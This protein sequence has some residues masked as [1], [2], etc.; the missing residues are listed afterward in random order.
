ME[1]KESLE[2]LKS[3]KPFIEWQNHNKDSFFSYALKMLEQ[4]KEQPWELGYYNQNTEKIASFVIEPEARMVNEEEAFKKPDEEIKPIDMAKVTLPFN[5]ILSKARDFHNQKYPAERE[6]KVIAILQALEGHDTVWNITILT[7]S[8]K[9][10]NMKIDP[11]TGKI[12]QH[13][14]ESLMDI[15]R[16]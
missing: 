6:N 11:Q 8:F 9:T 4:D 10:L 14:L 13:A 15:V 5:S 7:S 12:L 2:Q 1:I 3:S 16:K